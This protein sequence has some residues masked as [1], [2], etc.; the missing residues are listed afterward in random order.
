MRGG[1]CDVEMHKECKATDL[2][3]CACRCHDFEPITL[4]DVN[5]SQFGFIFR[6]D[7]QVVMLSEDD[8]F[9]HPV[10]SFD[11]AW[12]SDLSAAAKDGAARYREYHAAR[13]E[14]VLEVLRDKKSS[15]FL[16]LLALCH[17]LIEKDVRHAVIDLEAK[18]FVKRSRAD[19]PTEDTIILTEKGFQTQEG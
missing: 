19:N 10:D 6:E 7:G 4:P 5:R 8:G 2:T 3:Y 15:P 17:P 13:K 1:Y 16:E 12:L 14:K 18:G 11:P 9:W